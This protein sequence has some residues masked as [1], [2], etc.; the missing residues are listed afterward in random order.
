M[1]VNEHKA[2]V[3]AARGLRARTILEDELVKE[4]FKALESAYVAAWR[5]TTIDDVAGR[6]KL[7]LA[8]NILGKV[9]HHLSAIIADG[10][11]AEADLRELAQAAER[12][13]AWHEVR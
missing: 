10:K 8:I 5:S 12:K 4:G 13:K 2:R 1:E 7:F 3:D 9:Q 11:L 6:E